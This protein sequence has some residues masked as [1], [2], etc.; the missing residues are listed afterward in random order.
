MMS[1]RDGQSRSS[2]S[3]AYE[4]LLK[5][6][7][8]GDL[9]PG[10]RL[11]EAELAER[12]AI[13]RTPVREALSRLET[14]GL[15]THEPHQGAKV[16]SLDY[17]QITELY[18]VRELLEGSAAR[19]AAIHATGP[20]TEVLQEMVL[21]DKALCNK[22]ADLARTNR[23]FH[24]QIYCCARNRF[25]NQMLENMRLSLILLAGT[26]LGMPERGAQSVEEHEAVVSAIRA[27]DSNAAEQAARR[28]IR[29]SLKERIRL[30]QATEV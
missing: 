4:L 20:E 1:P 23:A 11:R 28:H 13:S 30:Y 14:Q 6:I 5:A 22:P 3:N 18:F 19:L 26:T 15:V 17:S 10:S 9:P 2:S 12:F 25:L 29:N 8:E 21:R 24:R 7:E 27:H 16:A